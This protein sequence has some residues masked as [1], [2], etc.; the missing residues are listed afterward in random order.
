MNKRKLD[1]EASGDVRW[2]PVSMFVTTVRVVNIRQAVPWLRMSSRRLLTSGA[3][4]APVSV[5]VRVCGLQGGTVTGLWFLR[6]NIILPWLSIHYSYII[7]RTNNR[8]I[9]GCVQ[10]HRPTP[11]TRTVTTNIWMHCSVFHCDSHSALFTSRCA[12]C[13]EISSKYRY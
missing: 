8:P 10:G 13:L 6:V 9:H 1:E 2:L 4:F 3:G 5:H 7:W 12:F 11:S